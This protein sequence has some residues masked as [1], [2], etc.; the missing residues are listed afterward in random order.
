MKRQI[1]IY[2]LLN[3][4]ALFAGVASPMLMAVTPAAAAGVAA[5]A[6]APA[7]YAPNENQCF[8]LFVLQGIGDLQGAGNLQGAGS[9]LRSKVRESRD[10]YLALSGSASLAL[11]SEF[12]ALDVFQQAE[13]GHVISIGSGPDVFRPLFDFPKAKHIHLLDSLEGWGDGPFDVLGEIEARLTE[14]GQGVAPLHLV[15]NA[16][17]RVWLVKWHVPGVGIMETYFHLHRL[18]YNSS[19]LMRQMLAT[20]PFADKIVGVVLTGAPKPSPSVLKLV[21]DRL[22]EGSKFVWLHFSVFEKIK[23]S[24]RRSNLIISLF[25]SGAA[26]DHLLRVSL[27]EAQSMRD[28]FRRRGFSEAII[29]DNA[30]MGFAQEIDIFSR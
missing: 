3:I 2:N 19:Q 14:L 24:S 16:T 17:E 29:S 15:K 9:S 7:A 8:R 21:T 23:S 18:N 28:L 27:S 5:A 6:A 12:Q 26:A 22:S 11:G 10:R 30:N 25:G 13:G 20:I 1:R 4:I